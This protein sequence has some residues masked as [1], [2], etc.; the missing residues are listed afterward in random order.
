MGS[1]IHVTQDAGGVRPGGIV[2]GAQSVH[3]D[4]LVRIPPPNHSRLHW[5]ESARFKADNS[6][7]DEFHVHEE[8][9]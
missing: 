5:A 6:R 9:D 3:Q 4:E 1:S 8:E 7:D 2:L